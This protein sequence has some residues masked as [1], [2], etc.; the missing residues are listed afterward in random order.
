MYIDSNLIY[1]VIKKFSNEAFQAL[2]IEIQVQ[3][4]ANITCGII[5]RQHSSPERFQAYFNET[6][7]RLSHSGK[8]IYLI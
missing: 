7:E 5:Y 3:N 1:T 2:W 6:I 8:P 4:G